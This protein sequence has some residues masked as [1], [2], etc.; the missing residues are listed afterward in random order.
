MFEFPDR[1]RNISANA[2]SGDIALNLTPPDEPDTTITIKALPEIGEILT[3]SGEG[4]GNDRTETL[5][6]EVRED[7]VPTDPSAWFSIAETSRD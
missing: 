3:Q 7:N 1:T 4:A 5:Y 6:I 2:A